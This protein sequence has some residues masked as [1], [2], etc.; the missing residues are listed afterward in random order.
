MLLRDLFQKKRFTLSFEFFPPKR[1]GNLENLFAVIQELSFLKPDF[2]SVTYGA[3][4]STRERSL[5]IAS[6]VKNQL[7]TEVLAHLTCVHSTKD[8]IGKILED[9]RNQNVLNILALR[10]DP[11]EGSGKFV[12]PDGGF[13][14]ASELVEFIK[15]RDNFSVGVA[16]S[17]EGHIEAPSLE[18]DLKNL[19]RKVDAGADFIITQLFFDNGFFYRFRDKICAMGIHI[20]LIPGIFPIMNFRQIERIA[21]LCGATIPRQLFQKIEKVWDRKEEVEKYGIEYAITQIDDLIRNDAAGIHIYSM[22]RS[23]AVQQI[24]R[25]LNLPE[26]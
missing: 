2:V 20:P 25:A 19:R 5:E 12:K 26:V 6:R 22:N 17:P 9:F 18:E 21:D 14:Y 24:L 1:E 4:G 11:P 3:G 10:G 8:E 15:R 7:N 23:E 13:S 16:G